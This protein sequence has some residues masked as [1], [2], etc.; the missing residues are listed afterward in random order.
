MY[1]QQDLGNLERRF[2]SF[3]LSFFLYPALENKD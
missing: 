3:F 2:L 1:R